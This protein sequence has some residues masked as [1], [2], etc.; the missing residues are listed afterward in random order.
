M[1]KWERVEQGQAS[2]VSFSRT[3]NGSSRHRFWASTCARSAPK[4]CRSRFDW[5]LDHA[6]PWEKHQDGR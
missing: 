2:H 1:V 4:P 6:S 3:M 5:G